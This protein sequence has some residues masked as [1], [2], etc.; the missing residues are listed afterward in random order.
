MS[1]EVGVVVVDVF[2]D[3]IYVWTAGAG[4][5]EAGTDDEAARRDVGWVERADSA[6]EVG[7]QI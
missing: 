4:R 6:G 7:C 2:A 3:A 5:R 1:S